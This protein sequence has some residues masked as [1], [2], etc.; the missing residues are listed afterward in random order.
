MVC[1]DQRGDDR[2]DSLGYLRMGRVEVHSEVSPLDPFHDS[3]ID[4]QWLRISWHKHL[5]GE[6]HPEGDTCIPG[7]VAP[8]QRKI[9]D[10]SFP[11][12]PV[13]TVL[14][15]H[16]FLEPLMLPHDKPGHAVFFL[17]HHAAYRAFLGWSRSMRAAHPTRSCDRPSVIKVTLQEATTVT[18]LENGVCGEEGP[19]VHLTDP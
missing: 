1:L 17:S 7:D 9:F 8:A 6:R 5:Q 2:G 14:Y 12:Y 19:P 15:R 3:A 11:S 10:D 13:P 18:S 16:Q 4:Q